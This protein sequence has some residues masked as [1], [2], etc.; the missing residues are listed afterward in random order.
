M[1][2]STRI[3]LSSLFGLAFAV[4]AFLLA[5][6]VHAEIRVEMSSGLTE[7]GHRGDGNWHQREYGPFDLDTRSQSLS[8]GAT[9]DLFDWRWRAGLQYLGKHSTKCECLSSDH[10]YALYKQGIDIGWPKSYYRTEGDAYGA[11]ATVAPLWHIDRGWHAFIEAGVGY[12]GVSND[13]TVRDW[14]P[15]TN[16]EHTTWGEPQLLKVKNGRKWRVTPIVGAGVIYGQT[17]IALSARHL[18]LDGPWYPIASETPLTLEIR[19]AW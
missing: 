4:F 6:P 16:A 15:A 10:A 18:N 14:Y 12:Y 11:Y 8:I 5:Q 17:S 13:V 3:I 9:G 7:F 1:N 19:H 2:A